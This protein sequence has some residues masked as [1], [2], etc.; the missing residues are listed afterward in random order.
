[1]TEAALEK[2]EVSLTAYG[3]CVVDHIAGRRHFISCIRST[4]VRYLLS[5]IDYPYNGR[6]DWPWY[7]EMDRKV[8]LLYTRGNDGMH[9]GLVL[10]ADNDEKIM[11]QYYPRDTVVKFLKNV[12]GACDGDNSNLS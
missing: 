4:L 5:H 8:A 7:K 10:F 11:Q 2:L 6:E 12:V 9:V 3:F 1:M